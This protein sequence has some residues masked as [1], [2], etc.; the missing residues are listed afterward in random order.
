MRK[1]SAAGEREREPEAPEESSH[2]RNPPWIS[3]G[4]A[5]VGEEERNSCCHGDERE[6]EKVRSKTRF[7]EREEGSRKNPSKSFRLESSPAKTSAEEE[8]GFVGEIPARSLASS[9]KPVP[10]REVAVSTAPVEPNQK[11]S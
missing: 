11:F 7:V 2:S 3:H 1:L 6:T 4:A 9:A 8:G 10:S 5:L